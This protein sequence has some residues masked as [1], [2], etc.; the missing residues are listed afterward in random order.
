[1]ALFTTL[2]DRHH[3]GEAGNSRPRHSNS[4]SAFRNL[5][6]RF[7][8]LSR[9]FPNVCF[10]LSESSVPVRARAMRCERVCLARDTYLYIYIYPSSSRRASLR[11]VPDRLARG[12]SR[13]RTRRDLAPPTTVIDL[14]T[15]V[16]S[17]DSGGW[18]LAPGFPEQSLLVTEI[19]RPNLEKTKTRISIYYRWTPSRPESSR[20]ST[21]TH[22]SIA[23]SEPVLKKRIEQE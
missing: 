17:F 5:P 20:D 7:K 23:A 13:A 16:V 3:T 6:E 9:W 4:H 15:S 14:G 12:N 8:N 21:S 19:A 1:M 10:D 11:V 2:I 22:P 18:K